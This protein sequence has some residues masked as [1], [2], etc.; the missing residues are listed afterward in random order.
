MNLDKYNLG[1]Y[2]IKHFNSEDVEF[3]MHC[4]ERI[5][6]MANFSANIPIVMTAVENLKSLA[7]LS[8]AIPFD[9][10]LS[11]EFMISAKAE[12]ALY[13]AMNCLEELRNKLS[14]CK[15]IS[16]EEDGK[17]EIVIECY[18]S[19]NIPFAES[20]VENFVVNEVLGN[21]NILMDNILL[22]EQLFVNANATQ[23][24][25]ETIKINLS[26]NKGDI[27][28][29]DSD[30]FTVFLNDKNVFDLYQGG[31]L[32][33]SRGTES[34]EIDSVRKGKLKGKIV[35]RERFL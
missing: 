17:E 33:L 25:D 14:I 19:K 11:E 7:T 24:D 3:T 5:D 29:I 9:L 8:V 26:L 20:Y 16:F 31:W 13:I 18:V 27:L 1:K 6:M 30:D 22:D 34:I 23:I 10:N 21:L 15:D 2:N 4:A 35:F 28:R 12:V 32:E